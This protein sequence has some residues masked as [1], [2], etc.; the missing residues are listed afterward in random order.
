MQFFSGNLWSHDATTGMEI[1]LKEFGYPMHLGPIG[2]I[3]VCQWKP[4]AITSG[5]NTFG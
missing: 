2:S 1:F 5:D 3:A 4:I